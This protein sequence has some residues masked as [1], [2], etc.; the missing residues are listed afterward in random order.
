M[1]YN[2]A[3]YDK[4]LPVL[5]EEATLEPGGYYGDLC[6]YYAG[7]SYM[8]QVEV[9][10]AREIWQQVVDR[11]P[12][13]SAAYQAAEASVRIRKRAGRGEFKGAVEGVNE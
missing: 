13:S 11:S 5:L 6:A 3:A 2:A 10:K 9:D 1:L 12:G 8:S 7:E 4:A